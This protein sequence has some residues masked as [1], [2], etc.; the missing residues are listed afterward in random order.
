MELAELYKKTLE[1]GKIP[2]F[3]L[4]GVKSIDDLKRGATEE[5]MIVFFE[6]D[7]EEEVMA[8]K[9]GVSFRD[10][11]KRIHFLT[12]REVVIHGNNVDIEIEK[13]GD[14][15]H[16]NLIQEYQQAIIEY[17]NTTGKDTIHEQS[18]AEK[19]GVSMD[20]RIGKWKKKE[21]K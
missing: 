12:D 19:I 5:V 15:Y 4:V 9:D 21:P 3:M 6:F 16:I 17:L 7:T 13:H 11:W 8:F 20:P 2:V 14:Q 1:A 10:Q 18:L